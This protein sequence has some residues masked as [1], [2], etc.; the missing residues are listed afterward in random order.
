MQDLRVQTDRKA[1]TTRITSSLRWRP[2]EPTTPPRRLTFNRRMT[3]RRPTSPAP[4]DQTETAATLHVT[5]HGA[6][7]RVAGVTTSFTSRLPTEALLSEIF[8]A[9][10]T[11][12]P[13][14]AGT[15]P[16][17][18]T[19]IR[20]VEFGSWHDV[21]ILPALG[22]W[23]LQVGHAAQTSNLDATVA[24][25]DRAQV[26]KGSSAAPPSRPRGE[27]ARRR[28]LC[29]DDEDMILRIYRRILGTRHEVVTVSSV[30]EAVT[31][32]AHDPAFDLILCDLTMPDATGDVLYEHVSRHHRELLRSFV[33]VT[34]G[35]LTP[36]AKSFLNAVPVPVALKPFRAQHLREIL[37]D[38]LGEL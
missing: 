28:V 2:H 36:E 23:V 4:G 11:S 16:S 20:S 3:D 12:W 33:I 27:P 24:P 1:V 22:G 18:K 17:H 26:E 10:P 35:A 5:A 6:I 21:D 38:F 19:R 34:G 9:L 37:A 30:A 8:D 15:P 31:A 13:S 25:S 7:T 14:V 32:L 29:V